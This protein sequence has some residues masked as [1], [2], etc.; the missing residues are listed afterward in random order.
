VCAWPGCNSKVVPFCR[1]HWWRLPRA[2]RVDVGAEIPGAMEKALEWIAA[3]LARERAV[4]AGW[5]YDL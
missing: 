2:M 5:Q 3:D 1:D 4:N